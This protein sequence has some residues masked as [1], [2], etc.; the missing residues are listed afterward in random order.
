MKRLIL[1]LTIAALVLPGTALAKGPSG[2][3]IDGPGAGGGISFGGSESSGPL[4]ALTEQAGFF[5]AVFRQQPDPMLAKS[6]ADELGP[7]YIVTY[8]VPGPNNEVWMLRQD[9]Y[10]YATPEPITYMAPGQQVY[11]T[12]N[13]RGGWFRAGPELKETLVAAGLPES[14][15]TGSSSDNNPFPTTAFGLLGIALLCIAATAVLVR[16]RARPTAA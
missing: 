16:R 7:R 6:P 11:E 13:T 2:A 14:L 12:E 10:P 4:G 8:T 1:T 5:P 15:S 9:V 3:T